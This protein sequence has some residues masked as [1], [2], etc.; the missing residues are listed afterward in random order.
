MSISG[1]VNDIPTERT[2]TVEKD[3]ANETWPNRR[4]IYYYGS[5]FFFDSYFSA[6]LT[7]GVH[8]VRQVP[9]AQESN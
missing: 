4:T 9:N 2:G 7:D 8:D 3:V 6:A 5:C 1:L